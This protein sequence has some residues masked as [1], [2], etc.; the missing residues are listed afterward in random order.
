MVAHIC[1]DSDQEAE[2]EEYPWIQSQYKRQSEFQTTLGY[3]GH[4]C[5]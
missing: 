1:H 3:R 5:V 4:P 2:A